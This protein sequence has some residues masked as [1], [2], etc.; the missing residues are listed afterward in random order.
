MGQ[1]LG[2]RAYC[3]GIS[4]GGLWINTEKNCHIDALDLKSI[5]LSP[6]SVVKDHGFM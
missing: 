3:E 1:C 4:T 2:A 5:L 6:M